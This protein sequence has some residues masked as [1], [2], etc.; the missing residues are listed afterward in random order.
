GMLPAPV[1]TGMWE[2]TLYG[3]PYKSNTQLLW[4]RKSHAAAAG[5]DPA[6]PTFTWDEMLKAAEQQQKKIAVQAQRYEGYTVWI[7]ALV[8]SGG[9]ELLQDVEAGRNAKPSMATPPGE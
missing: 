7:N 5:V 2:D 8:L 4:Y 3:A 6:S 9:G 1:E